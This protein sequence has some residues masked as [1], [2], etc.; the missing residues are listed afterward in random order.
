MQDIIESNE[1][2]IA[3]FNEM[4]EALSIDEGSVTVTYDIN[5]APETDPE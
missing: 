1:D 4:I 3:S 2:V 5:S